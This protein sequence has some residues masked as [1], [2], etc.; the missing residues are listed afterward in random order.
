VHL[1]PTPERATDLWLPEGWLDID[2]EAPHAR[3]RAEP[4]TGEARD[5]TFT[6]TLSADSVSKNIELLR[7]AT[8]RQSAR[9]LMRGAPS[10]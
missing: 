9:R 10:L 6:V 8:E 2:V 3:E 7:R 4:D 1:G 5:D